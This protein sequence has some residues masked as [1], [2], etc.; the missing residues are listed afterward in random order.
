MKEN[1]EIKITT[2]CCGTMSV[3]PSDAYIKDV[4]LPLKRIE[5]P[6]NAYLIEHPVHGNILVDTG[7]SEDAD[8]IL[9]KHLLDFYRPKIRKE[10]T[11]KNQLERMGI[12]PED[13]D[14]IILTHLDV[15]HT[16]AL[17]DFAGKAK[18]IVC[19]ELEYFYSC[20]VVYKRREV[21]D[22]W[23]PYADMIERIYLRASVLGP[24]GRG[25]DIFGDDSILCIY[26]PGHTDG[27]CSVMVNYGPSNR[28]I[29]HGM[30]KY[31]GD[32]CILSSDVAF[33][34]R[35]IDDLVE[36]GYGFNRKLQ[37]K[38]IEFLKEMQQDPH[39]ALTLYSHCKPNQDTII[40]Q[41]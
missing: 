6:V 32:F 24:T 29:D 15:D 9:P 13:I 41:K 1:K 17:K 16:C 11:A 40:L 27:I 2:L 12:R 35:N 31:G 26:C 4:S 22:T 39:H 14:L 30:G 36:P 38:S 28:F 25:F 5:L 20:R 21:W 19:S 18:R 37:R 33:S 7:W 34:R 23:M 8:K 3:R 10:D